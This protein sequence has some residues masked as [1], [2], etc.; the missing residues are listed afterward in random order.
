MFNNTGLLYKCKIK[1][2]RINKINKFSTGIKAHYIAI[3]WVRRMWTWL[4]IFIYTFN[5]IN[6]GYIY[7]KT[8]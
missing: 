8:P 3:I 5:L 7:V 6:K 4:S 1:D 2:F